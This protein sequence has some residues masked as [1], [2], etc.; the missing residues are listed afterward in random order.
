MSG[1]GG[2]QSGNGGYSGAGV[3]ERD[4]STEGA[5]QR[6]FGFHI[7]VPTDELAARLAKLVQRDGTLT[8]STDTC[9][10]PVV[11]SAPG[12]TKSRGKFGLDTEGRLVLGV[13][14]SNP[15][16]VCV[17]G[18]TIPVTTEGPPYKVPAFAIAPIREMKVV[19]R[20]QNNQAALK[21]KRKRENSG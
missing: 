8:E 3:S 13:H 15:P 14:S 17:K 6:Y 11:S 5:G 18:G 20:N 10:K 19:I 12:R 7:D 21:R 9:E 1:P 4:Y 2:R 16:G